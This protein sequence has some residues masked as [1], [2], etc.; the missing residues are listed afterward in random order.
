M[1]FSVPEAGESHD[2]PCRCGH[3]VTVLA[4]VGRQ[5]WSDLLCPDC[6]TEHVSQQ[7][8]VLRVA[9][10]RRAGAGIPLAYCGVELYDLVARG[11]PSDVVAAAEDW[12]LHGAG[13]FLF[14][15]NGTGKTTLAGVAAWA[16]ARSQPIR[17]VRAAQLSRWAMA[18]YGSPDRLRLDEIIESR[19]ALVL[20]DLGRELPSPTSLNPLTEMLEHR[21]E[22][23]LPLL[24]TSN[25]RV[26]Q[27]AAREG[28]GTWLGSRL[29]GYCRQFLMTGPDHRI[30]R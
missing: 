20:D 26:S 4:G 12:C 9:S 24:I 30:S 27:L 1:K 13:L 17:W 8:R 18:A 28:Y 6:E 22:S 23:G 14:G 29:A 11:W 10:A 15:P 21:I 5:D 19:T 25:F 2:V 16:L 7:R 3:T